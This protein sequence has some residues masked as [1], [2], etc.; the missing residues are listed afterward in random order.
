MNVKLKEARKK[1][2][3]TQVELA[4]R[5]GLNERTIQQYE[6]EERT[7]NVYMGQ[8]LANALDSTIED[9]FPLPPNL[10]QLMEKRKRR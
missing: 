10:A 4:R 5:T 6:G 9:I 1:K 3:M 2:N 7:P 8:L